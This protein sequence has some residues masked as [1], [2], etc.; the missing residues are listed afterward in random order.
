M[1]AGKTVGAAV[2][3]A[4]HSLQYSG[5]DL[6]LLGVTHGAVLRNVVPALRGLRVAACASHFRAAPRLTAWAETLSTVSGGSS[7]DREDKLAGMTIAG[8]IFDEAPRLRREVYDMAHSR[9]SIP[10]ARIWETANAAGPFHW[11]RGLYDKGLPPE[12]RMLSQAS[13]DN[14]HLPAR[15]R[16]RAS[17]DARRPSCAAPDRRGVGRGRR[18][19]LAGVVRP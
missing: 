12:S 14:P 13:R 7:V 8:G 17:G 18:G 6:L 16:V 4:A 19:D 5:V 1:R 10:G 15:V 2:A 9:A 3:L 11:Y